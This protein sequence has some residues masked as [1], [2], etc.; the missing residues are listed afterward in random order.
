M[1]MM[2]FKIGELHPNTPHLF[3][4]LAELLLL[5]NYGG[6]RSLHRSDIES[7]LTSGTISH[8][9]I[10]DEDDE[11]D[12]RGTSSA[13]RNGRIERQVDDIMTHLGYRAGALSA[14]YPF[15]FDGD[16]LT[17]HESLDSKQRV[18]RLLLACSRLR[19]FDSRGVAQRWAGSFTELS[20]IALI[21]LLPQHAT[22]RIFDANSQDRRDYYSTD[23]RQALRRLGSDLGV[24]VNEIECDKQAPQGDAG[25][26]LVGVI[27]LVD[28]AS[29]S[30]AILGQCG[31]QETNWPKKTLEAH[32]IKCRHFFHIQFDYPGVMFTP[33][34]FRT[35]T[36]EWFNNG[37]T[38]GIYL[39]DRSRILKLL[40]LQN[41]CGHIAA[42]PW[43]ATFEKEFATTM[44]PE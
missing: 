40:D 37:S 34:C 4:D 3:A 1:T 41:M 20:K 39:A 5:I 23:L 8:E 11:D 6:R 25:L 32:S 10:D 29:T 17:L 13:E 44:P 15:Q 35:A 21:G 9:E 33:V 24:A 28:G 42:L 2:N 43:F 22:V 38:N 36:G 27:D 12:F 16:K 30:F 31:A 26:D 7:V 18:Y 19:S 14:F